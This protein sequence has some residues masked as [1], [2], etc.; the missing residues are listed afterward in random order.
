[1]KIVR[2]PDGLGNDALVVMHNFGVHEEPYRKFRSIHLLTYL[3]QHH[4]NSKNSIDAFRLSI[5]LENKI[6]AVEHYL[7]LLSENLGSLSIG[8]Y[9]KHSISDYYPTQK[10]IAIIEGYINAIYSTLE[11]TS[12]LN[13]HLNFSLPKGFR[14]Q[15][16]KYELFSFERNEWLKHFY[17]IRTELAHYNSIIPIIE[18]DMFIIEFRNP[19]KLEVFKNGKHEVK[20]ETLLNYAPSLLNMLDT[21][22]KNE[23]QYIKKDAELNIIH[24]A[25]WRKPVINKTITL[26][27]LL[28][29]YA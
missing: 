29:R 6:Y 7:N 3:A 13:K 27:T 1:M 17:D 16:K 4:E 23:L 28:E 11:V 12:E 9:E 15:A 18:R 19:S 24:E 20:F 21:W 26:Q 14:R 2:I 10:T 25:G 22:S 5:T 8:L